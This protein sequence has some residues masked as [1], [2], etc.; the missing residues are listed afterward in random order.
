L[1]DI[2]DNNSS[3]TLKWHYD[4]LPK[5]NHTTAAYLSLFKGLSSVFSDY[6][7]PALTN[8]QTFK[9]NGGMNGLTQFFDNRGTKYKDSKMVP[10]QN[11]VTLAYTFMGEKKFEQAN[12]L[13]ISSKE[14]YSNPI[15][16]LGAL[17]YLNEQINN[18]SKAMQA[19]QQALFFANENDE[20]TR[21]KKFY[22]GKVDALSI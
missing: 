20:P 15:R 19:Y 13:L 14:K 4:F 12:L 6:E 10:Q 8:Y 18:R 9:N 21:V 1:S 7:S 11:I 22:Q 16:I 3:K 2:F 17:G 5:Q